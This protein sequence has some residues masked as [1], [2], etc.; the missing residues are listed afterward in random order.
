M[1]P[2]SFRKLVE[3]GA[4]CALSAAILWWFGRK[5]DWVEVGQAVSHSNVYLLGLAVLAVCLIYLFQAYRW[6]ALLTPI[7]PTSLKHVFAALTVGFTAI[8][9]FGRLGELVRPVVLPLRDPKVRPSASVVTMIVERI[10]DLLAILILFSANLLWLKPPAHMS[11]EWSRV[12]IAGITLLI[13]AVAGIVAL[14]W[15]RRE[16][17]RTVAWLNRRLDRWSFIPVRLTAIII[18]TLEHLAKALRILVDARSLAVTIGWTIAVWAAIAAANLL[19]I[20]AFG[21]PFGITETIFVLGWSIV[22]SLVPTPGGAAGAFHAATAAGLILL[23][24]E[25]ETSA[26]ISIVVHLIGFGPALFFGVLY[27]VRGDINLTRL[28]SLTSP[29]AIEH[30]VE[31]EEI[32]SV[33]N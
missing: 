11:G 7:S 33:I 27:L 10:F 25:R 26:A 13:G 6:R 31:E 4:L 19:V 8:F 22:G 17:A 15:F 1:T 28:R 29:K 3:F 9:V 32:V 14:N 24:V 20:R 23:G 5:L 12:R 30:A 18:R 21:V 2:S 16:S